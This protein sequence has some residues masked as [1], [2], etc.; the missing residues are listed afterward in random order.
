MVDKLE[1]RCLKFYYHMYSYPLF[2]LDAPD[3]GKLTL[4]LRVNILDIS[5]NEKFAEKIKRFFKEF[6][7][8][9]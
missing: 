7:R 1:K 5:I 8:R 9:N 6:K 3:I 2:K 4:N